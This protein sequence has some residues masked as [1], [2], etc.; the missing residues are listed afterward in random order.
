MHPLL[1]AIRLLWVAP[2][3]ILASGHDAAAHDE[4]DV[5][6]AGLS[7]RIASHPDSLPLYLLR[8]ELRR[9]Q[10]DYEGARDDFAEVARR[11]PTCREL[12]LRRA[13]LALDMG[14]PA[15]ARRLMDATLAARP[16][17]P[18]ALRLR[19]RALVAL[20]MPREAIADLGAMLANV[21]HPSPDHYLDRARLQIQQGEPEA[22][23][24]G[25]D[26]ARERLG[27]VVSL[28]LYAIEIGRA[29][30]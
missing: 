6:I 1:R 20:G 22:A 14:A 30:V 10:G 7:L 11:D 2:A 28:E 24:R 19:S 9:I 13:A 16:D 25:L 12:D 23:L 15:E 5:P 8:G 17:E 4:V 26:E 18:A 21:A 3:I 27:A 29:H